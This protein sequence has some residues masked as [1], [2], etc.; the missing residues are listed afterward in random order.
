MYLEDLFKGNGFGHNWCRSCKQPIHEDEP[1]T[2][3][4]F[5]SDPEGL[6]GLTGDYHTPC[7][8]PFASLARALDML[9]RFGR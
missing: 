1:T 4:E 7:S 6:E 5:V 8:R 9:S 3:V 2:R